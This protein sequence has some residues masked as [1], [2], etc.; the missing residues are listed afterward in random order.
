M[1]KFFLWTGLILL[2]P[3][4]LFI[5]L[6][7]LLYLPPVQNWAVDKVAEI[8]SEKTGMQISVDRISLVFPLDLGIDGVLV[9][10]P[11]RDTIANIEHV[12]VDVELMS[13]TKGQVVVD[14]LSITN[15]KIN[16]YDFLSDIHIR[17]GVGSLS[18]RSRSI[19]LSEGTIDVDN[20]HLADADLTI[21]LSDTAV[22]DTAT[23]E[24]PWLIRVDSLSVLRSQV[25]LHTP[26]DS[27]HVS[28]YLGQ[29][30]ASEGV[31]D[32]LHSIFS[33][34]SFSW[35][36]G[37]LSYDQTFEP[38]KAEG[39][40]YNHITLSQIGIGLDS[41]YFSSPN[42]ALKIRQA[43]MKEQSGLAITRLSG[44]VL[45]DSASLQ[46]PQLVLSTPYS[47]VKTQASIDFSVMDSINP[48]RLHAS[49]QT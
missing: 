18:A 49:L 4:L 31:F 45:L 7:V 42:L 9:V 26:G 15:F 37:I 1:K 36:D 20:L 30:G 13:L 11:E 44:S 10:R 16:T 8:A 35:Y 17:G 41:I 39:L 43:T 33:V 25:E 19:D 29:A 34:R 21:L 24:T 14:Q 27:I 40:D 47:M 2:S 28:A 46:L 5:I 48:G 6:T 32:L 22:V 3:I 12:A 23:S 38:R